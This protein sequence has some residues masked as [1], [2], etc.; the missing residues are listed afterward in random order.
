LLGKFVRVRITNPVGSLN[1]QY[2]YRYSLNFGSLEGRRQ[3]DNRFA[4]AYI[5]GVHHP[6]RHF[7]GRTI[8]VLYREGERKGILVVAPKNMR[9]IGYQIADAL[10]FAEPEGTYRLECLYERSCG[11]V[12]CRRINGEIRLLLIKN[13]RSAHWGFPKGHMER[14][15]TPEQTARREVLEETGIHIDIIPDFTAKSDYTIQGKVEKSVTIFLAKTEDTETIIQREE[16]DDY[17]WLGFD[18][19]LETLKFENDKA[20]LKSARRFMDKHGIF[21]TDD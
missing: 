14:G 17:I 19:A 4:G 1:R 20:I 8:A 5:M 16:I 3:F 6:V 12:V 18:K 7:D 13:S 15:E 2:G 9:F 10:A 11:A 21:E